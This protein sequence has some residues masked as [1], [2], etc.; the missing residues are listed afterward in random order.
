MYR[1]R[2]HQ[3]IYAG[4]F[5]DEHNKLHMNTNKDKVKRDVI[6][7]NRDSSG[8]FT[9]DNIQYIYGFSYNSECA[10]KVAVQFFRDH[11]KNPTL[12]EYDTWQDFVELGIR[13]MSNYTDI[14]KFSAIIRTK[15]SNPHS[16]LN[17]VK[18]ELLD[19]VSPNLI[20]F[21][22]VKKM[23]K[24][25]QFDADKAMQCLLQAGHSK[26]NA[27]E[28]ISETVEHFEELKTTNRLFEM[29]KFLPRAVRSGF[30]DF[31]KF[32]TDSERELY[33]SLQGVDVLIYDDLFTSGATVNEIARYLRSINPNNKLT[34]FVLIKQ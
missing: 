17:I 34:V 31:L 28:I 5:V 25:V 29:K 18:L 9:K 6:I 16:I 10:D 22:L 13:N 32:A 12:E 8:T 19:L 3:S 11:L 23:Y 24:D 2:K 27:Q 1:Y 26:A 33:M 4:I 14:T 15:P 30:Y 21:E 7:L 20:N